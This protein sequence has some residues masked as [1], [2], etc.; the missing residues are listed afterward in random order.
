MKSQIQLEGA[1]CRLHRRAI[2][3]LIGW[4][5]HD[6]SDLRTFMAEVVLCPE[7]SRRRMIARIDRQIELTI[8]K[9]G[10]VYARED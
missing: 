4:S 6:L 5:L 8:G 7:P 2:T 9:Q 10:G 1:V 3:A